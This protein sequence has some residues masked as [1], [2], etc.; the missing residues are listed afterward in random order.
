MIQPVSV[1]FKV[2]LLI[3]KEQL[4]LVLIIF[5][6]KLTEVCV[7]YKINKQIYTSDTYIHT[8]CIRMPYAN[9]ISGYSINGPQT[10]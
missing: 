4:S 7:S 6:M 5:Y 9:S 1:Y 3:N 10:S 2:F 8:H